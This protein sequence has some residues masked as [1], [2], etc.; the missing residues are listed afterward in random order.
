MENRSGLPQACFHSHLSDITKCLFLSIHNFYKMYSSQSLLTQYAKK[1]DCFPV[2]VQKDCHLI[3]R[4]FVL[5][6]FK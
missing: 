5:N 4:H 1:Y 3:F 2:F 6:S